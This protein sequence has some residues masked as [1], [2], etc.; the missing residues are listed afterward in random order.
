M[1]FAEGITRVQPLADEVDSFKRL[2]S[3]STP[4]LVGTAFSKEA[5]DLVNLHLQSYRDANTSGTDA[6]GA[7]ELTVPGND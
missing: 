7:G 6:S 4:E 1:I 3:D 2:V 5:Y